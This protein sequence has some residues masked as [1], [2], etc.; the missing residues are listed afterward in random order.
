MKDVVLGAKEGTLTSEGGGFED[1]DTRIKTQEQ[2]AEM[3]LK[4]FGTKDKIGLEEFQHSQESISSDMLLSILNLLKMKLPCTGK[5][6]SLEAEFKANNK[7]LAESKPKKLASPA[8][9]ALSPTAS[10]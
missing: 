10:Q 4:C 6:Q 7:G 5:F 3:V 9:R 2:I 8:M 1:F